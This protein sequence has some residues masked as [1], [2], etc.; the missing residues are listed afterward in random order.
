MASEYISP[1]DKFV[2]FIFSQNSF[3]GFQIRFRELYYAYIDFIKEMKIDLSQY[4]S[5]DSTQ[6]FISTLTISLICALQSL[7]YSDI[8]KQLIH[9]YLSYIS[10][11]LTH[12]VYSPYSKYGLNTCSFFC[13]NLFGPSNEKLLH[14]MV[15]NELTKIIE[16]LE[17]DTSFQSIQGIVDQIFNDNEY[18]NR[19]YDKYS[20]YHFTLGFFPFVKISTRYQYKKDIQFNYLSYLIRYDLFNNHV[21]HQPQNCMTLFPY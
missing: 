1:V 6:E 14:H 2:S 11:I 18:L 16:Q 4:I 5:K 9:D 10:Q 15:D 21:Y 7:S 17:K 19:Y 12:T 13:F 8:Q 3:G 20:I